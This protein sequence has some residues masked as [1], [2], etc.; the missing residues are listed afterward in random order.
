MSKGP[1]LSLAGRE[2]EGASIGRTYSEAAHGRPTWHVPSAEV[3]HGRSRG[4]ERFPFPPPRSRSRR[5]R[6][7]CL[8]LQEHRP[9]IPVPVPFRVSGLAWPDSEPP[10]PRKLVYPSIRIDVSFRPDTLDTM[11]ASYAR[12]INGLVRALCAS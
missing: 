4:F 9:E 11:P 12:G 10:N 3:A 6:V 2:G 7:K 5:S 8:P 1:R